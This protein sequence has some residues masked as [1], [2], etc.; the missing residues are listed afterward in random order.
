MNSRVCF[1]TLRK[2]YKSPQISNK[3]LVRNFSLSRFR[4]DKN[5]ESTEPTKVIIPNDKSPIETSDRPRISV[6]DDDIYN[7]SKFCVLK[8][9]K[10]YKLKE[11]PDGFGNAI[12]ELKMD[13]ADY[14]H[15]V[16]GFLGKPIREPK[17]Y[18]Q[19]MFHEWCDI[20]IIGGGAMGT[21]CAYW[22]TTLAPNGPKVMVCEKD[23][24][25]T[26]TATTLSS[27]GLRQQFSLPES[28]EMSLF[29][30]DFIRT[31][32]RKLAIDKEESPDP[33]FQ[34]YGCLLLASEAG[35]STLKE[36][37]DLQNKL[38]AKNMLLSPTELKKRF[39]W[40]STDGVELGC[41][42][43]KNE[44]WFDP[45]SLLTS[46]RRKAT[47][48]GCEFR[49]YEVIGMEY[50]VQEGDAHHLYQDFKRPIEAIVRRR[51]G[52]IGTVRFAFAIIAAGADSKKVGKFFRFGLDEGIYRC[53]VPV[54]PRK[55]YVYCFHTPDGP[56][57]D[58]PLTVD[59]DGTYFRRDGLDGHYICGV[60]PSPEEEEPDTNNWDVDYEL[61]DNKV[62]PSLANRVPAFEKIKLKSAWTG[63]YEYNY[64]DMNGIVG[65]HPASP[66]VLFACGFS[67]HGIQH[68]PAVGRALAEYMYLG[69]YKTINLARLGFNRLAKME[70]LSERH[71]V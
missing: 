39:P 58:T 20:L 50:D 35:A 42:G 4:Q 26:T 32:K 47:K 30:A 15:D 38:G 60:S 7:C 17:F 22:L 63:F 64:I 55:R 44:G 62:W 10:D 49:D 68:A 33:S 52:V 3:Y 51:D 14:K 21:S 56:G 29:G 34:P 2:L 12:R 59:P 31:M 9:Y 36:N 57:L 16:M 67:G 46:L 8:K 19:E 41:L 6:T 37:S 43:L 61:F 53:P 23:S 1:Q 65:S 28:I 71:I 48:L 40:I 69:E 18:E 45:W 13:F 25:Y 66:N 54:E 27:G 11:R 5:D 24:K 70:P